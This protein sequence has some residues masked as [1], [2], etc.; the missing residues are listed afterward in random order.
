M[1]KGNRTK[2]FVSWAAKDRKEQRELERRETKKQTN[3]QLNQETNAIVRK[4]E[5][6]EILDNVSYG[7]GEETI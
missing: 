2:T 3:K 7:F 6:K 5:E 4:A 1:S